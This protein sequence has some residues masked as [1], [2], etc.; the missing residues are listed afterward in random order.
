MGKLINLH[1]LL[2]DAVKIRL[3]ADVDVGLFLSGGID[4]VSVAA[5][6]AREQPLQTISL[7]GREHLPE[8]GCS[9]QTSGGTI[10]WAAESSSALFVA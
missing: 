1:S 5:F 2:A 7:L 10:S 9:R 4:S 8:W 3:M 6:A